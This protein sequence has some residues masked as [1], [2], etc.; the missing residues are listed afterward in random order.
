[1]RLKCLLL[2]DD[3]LLLKIVVIYIDLSSHMP[4]NLPAINSG[5]QT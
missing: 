4:A 5:S 1:M 3:H 2:V